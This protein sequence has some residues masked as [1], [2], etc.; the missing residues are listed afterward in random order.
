VDNGASS[1][2]A[3]VGRG[4]M[5]E[6]TNDQPNGTP[7]TLPDQDLS[8]NTEQ[9]S[10]DIDYVKNLQNDAKILLGHLAAN[11]ERHLHSVDNLLE[12]QSVNQSTDSNIREAND[13]ILSSN[14]ENFV[15][16]MSVI[17]KNADEISKSPNELAILA[18]FVD[19]M[20][21]YSSPANARTI[22]ITNIY[23]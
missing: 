2:V 5:T 13:R 9:N 7:S 8:G 23:L 20:S 18:D 11:G 1:L 22:S 19:T 17:C 4:G 16:N 10:I 15:K 14:H 21:R 3:M 12:I 6:L